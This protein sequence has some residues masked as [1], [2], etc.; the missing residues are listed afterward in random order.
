M[1]DPSRG[2]NLSTLGLD[3]CKTEAAPLAEECFMQLLTYSA[4]CWSSEANKKWNQQAVTRTVFLKN[5]GGC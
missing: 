5:S 1:L 4:L 2:G 3:T